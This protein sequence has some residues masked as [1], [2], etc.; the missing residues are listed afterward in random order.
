M[1]NDEFDVKKSPRRSRCSLVFDERLERHASVMRP[2]PICLYYGGSGKPLVADNSLSMR[3]CGACH[4]IP[5][6]NA[7]KMLFHPAGDEGPG[8]CVASCG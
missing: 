5:P 7:S 3:D 2:P 8:L 6:Y 1:V 4:P